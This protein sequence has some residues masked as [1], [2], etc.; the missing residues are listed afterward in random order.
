[1]HPDGFD[2][3]RD[4]LDELA[5]VAQGSHRQH[6]T[7]CERIDRAFAALRAKELHQY[8]YGK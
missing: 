2:E 6:I 3:T 4:M 1:M 8:R 7:P 5:Q